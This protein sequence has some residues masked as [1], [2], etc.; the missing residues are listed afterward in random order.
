M[1]GDSQSTTKTALFPSI[2]FIAKS[3]ATF[4]ALIYGLGFVILTFHDAA[5]GVAQFSAFRTR[6]LLVGF[7]FV[8]VMHQGVEGV[9]PPE[10]KTL[11]PWH[12]L[13]PACFVGG[14]LLVG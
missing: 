5:Y 8:T 13:W 12:W 2:D 3:T 7:V 14:I 10:G 4:V 11:H 9:S 1:E 6:I